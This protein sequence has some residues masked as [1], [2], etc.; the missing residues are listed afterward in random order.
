MAIEIIPKKV[1][2]KPLNLLNVL[3][4]FSLIL[5]IIFLLGSLA[6]FFFQK[7]LNKTLQDLKIKI[8]AKGTPE[9][10]ALEKRILL[11]QKK[12]DDFADLM[13]FHQSNLK[14]FTT[15]ESLT[16]PK[17]FFSKIDLEI[18]KGKISLS[19][20]TE[21]FE[22]LGQQFL[23]LKKEDYIKNVNLSKL[24]ISKEGKIEF[25]FEILFA[26]EKFKY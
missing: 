12:I 14:F 19:G 11:T 7:N 24:S 22:V 9:E 3:F 26:P 6:L 16:H 25:T 13:N 5:L 2:A 8:A 15:L 21:N 18:N 17:I 20:I 10:I 1:G 4:Y 23:I